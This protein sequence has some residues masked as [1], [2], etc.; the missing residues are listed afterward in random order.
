MTLEHRVA[1]ALSCPV[2]AVAPLAAMSETGALIGT[3][4]ALA[5]LL[6]LVVFLQVRA[7]REVS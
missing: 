4:V 3:A 5:A 7:R 1:L 6:V 2:V